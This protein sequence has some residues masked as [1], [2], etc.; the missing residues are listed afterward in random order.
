MEKKTA[1][2]VLANVKTL[3]EQNRVSATRTA[4]AGAAALGFDFKAMKEVLKNLETGDLF[5]SMTSHANHTVWQDVYHFPSEEAG[6]IYLK[7]SVID[8]VLI[9]SFKEL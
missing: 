8:G 7:L 1:H 2:Y 4:L 3:V 6:D 5:K 9:V